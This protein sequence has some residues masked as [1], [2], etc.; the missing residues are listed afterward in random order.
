MTTGEKI[1]QNNGF[2]LGIA[3]KGVIKISEGTYEDDFS[4][5]FVNPN[6]NENIPILFWEESFV[7][8]ITLIETSWT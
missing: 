5:S 3:S 7:T 4:V 2:I 6:I 1:A 8:G